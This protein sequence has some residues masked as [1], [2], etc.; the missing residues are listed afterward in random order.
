MSSWMEALL[1]LD[2]MI[3]IT[4]PRKFKFFKLKKVLMPIILAV[5]GLIL[6]IHFENA[7]YTL[8]WANSTSALEAG[9]QTLVSD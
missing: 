2:R 3:C 1:A 5:F 8:I 6:A 4:F 7:A 9:N